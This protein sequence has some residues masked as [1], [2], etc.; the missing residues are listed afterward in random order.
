MYFLSG[1]SKGRKEKNGGDK[2]IWDI[3][4]IYMEIP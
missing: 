1:G 4:H 3:M 2:L